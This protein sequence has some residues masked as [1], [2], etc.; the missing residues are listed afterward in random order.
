MKRLFLLTALVS[1]YPVIGSIRSAAAA[2]LAHLF[3]AWEPVWL[4]PA[5]TSPDSPWYRLS[6]RHGRARQAS[7]IAVGAG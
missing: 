6:L 3:A 2:L 7:R 1:L 4:D 5:A